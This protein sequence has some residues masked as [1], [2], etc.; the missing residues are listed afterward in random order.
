MCIVHIKRLE[1]R[2]NPARR[3]TGGD[4]EFSIATVKPLSAQ[5]KALWGTMGQWFLFKEILKNWNFNVGVFAS[6]QMKDRIVPTAAS[7]PGFNTLA[8][9]DA[10][11]W[12]RHL[13]S[14]PSPPAGNS[15]WRQ[16]IRRAQFAEYLAST[17]EQG[18]LKQ[19][20][21]GCGEL[22]SSRARYPERTGEANVSI[23]TVEH[24]RQRGGSHGTF[25]TFHEILVGPSRGGGPQRVTR[26]AC[27][28]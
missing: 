26:T 11:F 12:Q 14:P 5:R 4:T 10:D 3:T 16:G 19:K 28:R 22:R 15:A 9:D 24:F 2:H 13:W 27:P 23:W 6:E 1:W 7:M 8:G 18:L 20:V 17:C 21:I 25:H